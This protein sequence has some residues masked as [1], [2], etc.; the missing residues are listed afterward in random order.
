MTRNYCAR[1]VFMTRIARR[2]RNSQ[3]PFAA[4]RC[5]CHS[6]VAIIGGT[7][8]G[9]CRCSERLLDVE[10]AGCPTGR[11]GEPGPDICHDGAGA[12]SRQGGPKHQRSAQF[13]GAS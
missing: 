8:R 7:D 4:S 6:R 2:A 3:N 10:R 5:H 12:G 11:L 9:R 13:G 1:G